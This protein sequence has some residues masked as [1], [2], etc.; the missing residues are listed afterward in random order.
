MSKTTDAS[1]PE[2][3]ELES[4]IHNA[5]LMAGLLDEAMVHTEELKVQAVLASAS[6]ID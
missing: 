4:A 1:E 5:S 6:P 3:S 2:L